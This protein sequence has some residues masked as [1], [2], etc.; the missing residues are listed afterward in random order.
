MPVSEIERTE[1]VNRLVAAIG[2]ES[3]ETLMKCILPDGRG[4]LA[5]KD[6]LNA[7]KAETRGEFAEFRAE[8]R[9]EFAEMRGYIDSSL[10]RQTRL[11]ATLLVGMMLAFWGTM[12]PFLIA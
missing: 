11:Y 4:Q 1:L 8:T 7:L 2:E 10:G 12:L 9:G 6:D 3:T 5:T